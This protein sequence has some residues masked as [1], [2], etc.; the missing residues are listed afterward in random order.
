MG[1]SHTGGLQAAN[2]SGKRGLGAGGEPSGSQ[3]TCARSY[4]QLNLTKPKAGR[5]GARG[6]GWQNK[7][8]FWMSSTQ[9]GKV[10]T[11]GDEGAV[12]GYTCGAWAT[13]CALLWACGGLCKG[14]Q[15][16]ASRR[17]ARVLICIYATDPATTAVVAPG[18]P[19]PRT[20]T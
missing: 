14:T 12:S 6:A 2:G 1:S 10:E 18:T 17:G 15:I 20:G 4:W 3:R 19:P 9:W 7:C 5:H 13:A 11:V 16:S 8:P